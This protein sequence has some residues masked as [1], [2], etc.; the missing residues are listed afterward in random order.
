[1]SCCSWPGKECKLLDHTLNTQITIQQH[2]LDTT[3]PIDWSIWEIFARAITVS[4]DFIKWC[5]SPGYR[6]FPGRRASQGWGTSWTETQDLPGGSHAFWV[7]RGAIRV[8][9]PGGDLWPSPPSR[10]VKYSL[11]KDVRRTRCL[12]FRV[13]LPPPPPNFLNSLLNPVY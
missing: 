1:M 10:P 11:K 9:V 8:A 4:G 7:L 3:P 13:S 6:T 2:Q 5:V 12:I